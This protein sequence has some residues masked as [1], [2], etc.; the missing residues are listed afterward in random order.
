MALALAA[1]V[2]GLGIA[3]GNPEPAVPAVQLADPWPSWETDVDQAS[4]PPVRQRLTELAESHEHGE[5]HNA[6][7]TNERIELLKGGQLSSWCLEVVLPSMAILQSEGYQVRHVRMIG[8]TTDERGVHLA[9]HVLEVWDNTDERWIVADIDN[10]VVLDQTAAAIPAGWTT[11]TPLE[12]EHGDIDAEDQYPMRADMIGI[13]IPD[14]GVFYDP[15]IYT[16]EQVAIME[17]NY[18]QPMPDF[19]GFFYG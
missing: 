13:R 18:W 10:G 5:T 7:T 16:T 9:H 6:L 15:D 2:V 1:V 12:T 11:P 17:A 3:A 8:E 4:L 14:A 19:S